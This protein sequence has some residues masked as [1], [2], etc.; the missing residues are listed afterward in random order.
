MANACVLGQL[1]TYTVEPGRY[2][3][4]ARAGHTPGTP[5]FQTTTGNAVR[6]CG[7]AAGLERFGKAQAAPGNLGGFVVSASPMTSC[8]EL[9]GT[10]E[11]EESAS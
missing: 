6:V 7:S 10:I 2:G 5:E 3:H 11:V 4:K 9:W 1:V 8:L